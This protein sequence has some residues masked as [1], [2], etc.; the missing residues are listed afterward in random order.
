MRTNIDIDDDLIKKARALTKSKSKKEIVHMA[1]QNLVKHLQRKK[2]LDY[3]GKI[4][5][6]GDLKTMRNA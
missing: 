4:K 2:M 5:W 3:K 6:E 1:L